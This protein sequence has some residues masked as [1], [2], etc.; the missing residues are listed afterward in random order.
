HFAPDLFELKRIYL[1]PLQPQGFAIFIIT[2]IFH[3]WS[4]WIMPISAYIYTSDQRGYISTSITHAAPC[5]FFWHFI[6]S[7]LPN[8]FIETVK[9]PA[10]I[11]APHSVQTGSSWRAEGLTSPESVLSS[12]RLSASGSSVVLIARLSI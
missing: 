2:W 1:H 12:V 9:I 11:L 5:D 7:G 10:V 8:L 3:V 6:Q 4:A